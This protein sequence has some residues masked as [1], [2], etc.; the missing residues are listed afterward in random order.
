MSQVWSIDE[1]GD[2]MPVNVQ[3][4]GQDA[5]L[6]NV[7]TRLREEYGDCFFDKTAGIQWTSIFGNKN[8][9]DVL[10][11][12]VKK[13][14]LDTEGVVLLRS[15]DLSIDENRKVIIQAQLKT[16]YSDDVL[17]FETL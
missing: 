15:F 14:I 5:V 12:S 1:T 16:I 7:I 10:Y 4:Y 2:W 8:Q 6:Q 9:E 17:F 13:T 11:F 3:L